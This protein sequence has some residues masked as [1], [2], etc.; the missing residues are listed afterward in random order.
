MDNIKREEKLVHASDACF[1]C[2]EFKEN[3]L[4]VMEEGQ[5]AL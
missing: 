5:R 4:M 2:H 1:C 3:G